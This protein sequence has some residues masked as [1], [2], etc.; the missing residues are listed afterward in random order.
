MKKI[1]SVILSSLTIL[2]CL[3]GCGNSLKNVIFNNTVVTY[4]GK[5]HFIEASNL[6]SGVSV[7]YEN[8]SFKDAGEY[9]VKVIFTKENKDLKTKEVKLTINPRNVTVNID[10]KQSMIDDIEELT[11]TVEGL[12]E[13]DD[14]GISLS[15]DSSSSG[16]KQIIG[17][18]DNDNYQVTFNGGKYVISEYLF[19]SSYLTNYASEFLPNLKQGFSFIR[20]NKKSI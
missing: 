3:S 10:D 12:I 11:Y 8:N 5:M 1:F 9:L 2:T 14:L 18:W 15:V 7:R 6:P 13:G 4:D 16:K 19:D 20:N 17:S